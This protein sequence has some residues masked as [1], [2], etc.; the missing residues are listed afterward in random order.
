[1]DKQQHLLG[2]GRKTDLNSDAFIDIKASNARIKR[3]VLHSLFFALLYVAFPL[4][5]FLIKGFD[6]TVATSSTSVSTIN[7]EVLNSILHDLHDEGLLKK[8]DKAL[9]MSPP[10]GFDGS[11]SLLNWNNEVNVVMHE[12]SYDFVFTP[13]FEDVV[14][15]DPVLKMNG[16]VAFPLS[17]DESSRSG[18]RKQSN[19][20]VVYLRRYDSIFVALRKGSA[21]VAK[22][23]Y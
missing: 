21:T 13:N 8:E 12:S 18:F 5:S 9:I 15:V 11:A 20:S 6:A 4:W 14:S 23:T 3:I 22:T 2:G 16:I 1:M 19:Y 10:P 7:L 17:V